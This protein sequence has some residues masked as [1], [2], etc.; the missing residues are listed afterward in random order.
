MRKKYIV[1]ASENKELL[2][3]F[4]LTIDHDRMFEAVGQI[5]VASDRNWKSHTVM[6][7]PYQPA[8]LPMA[9]APD[10]ARH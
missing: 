8:S 7:T 1:I 5:R 4:P 6:L 9:A 2:F 10:G 3:T